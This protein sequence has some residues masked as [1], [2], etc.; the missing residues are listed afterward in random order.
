MSPTHTQTIQITD[1]TTSQLQHHYHQVHVHL[2]TCWP[3]SLLTP[4]PRCCAIVECRL[5]PNLLVETTSQYVQMLSFKNVLDYPT[6]TKI[7][8]RL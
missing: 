8:S 7:K 2:G 4:R 1:T 6:I 3:S 5:V